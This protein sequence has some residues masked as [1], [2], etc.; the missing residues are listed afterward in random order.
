MVRANLKIPG[1]NDK[2]NVR[3]CHFDTVRDTAGQIVTVAVSV[4]D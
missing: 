2:K 1:R 4:R 3:P